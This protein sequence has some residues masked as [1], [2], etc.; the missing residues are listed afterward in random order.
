MQARYRLMTGQIAEASRFLEGIGLVSKQEGTSS[1]F[2]GQGVSVSIYRNGT[3]L[4]SCSD[5][6]LEKLLS[7]Y[8]LTLPMDYGRY[9][10]DTFGVELPEKWIGSDEAGKGDYFGPLVVAG[11]CVDKEIAA[12]LHRLGLTDSKKLSEESLFAYEDMLRVEIGT[13]RYEILAISPAKYNE[14]H[15]SMGNVLDIMAWAH[16]KVIRTLADRCGCHASIV[17]KFATGQRAARLSRSV[18]GVV[19]HQFT[20]GERDM[21]VAGASVLASCRF[22]RSM[23]A[24]SE[25]LGRTLPRGAGDGARSA[26]AELRRERGEIFYRTVAKADFRL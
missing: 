22:I 16:S 7:D 8:F 13:D 12:R 5:R 18:S 9:V 19:I 1:V 4:L 6:A 25:S 17:D 11:I 24:I 2:R 20:K 21:A 26:A 10:R 14:L 15:D 23:E 3:V